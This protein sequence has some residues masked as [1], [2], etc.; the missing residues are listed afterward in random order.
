MTLSITPNKR[1]A[2]NSKLQMTLL[3]M[4]PKKRIRILKTLGR[5]ER[6]QARARIRRQQ[7]VSG[8]PFEP[9]SNGK[10][11]R[12]LKRLG[13]TLEPYVQQ[14]SRLELKH[15]Q[16]LTGRIAALQQ[17]GGTEVMTASKMR[18]IHGQP[19]YDAPASRSQAKAL[20]AEGYKVRKAKGGWRRA[21]LN[22]IQQR[23]SVGQAGVIL[24]AMR[25]SQRKQRWNIPVP[26]REFLGDTTENVQRQLLKII[27]QTG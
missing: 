20:A 21:S 4:P 3:A 19:D 26:A 8:E 12:M 14:A 13:K 2:L 25:D 27:Q 16:T 23:L 1:Q 11:Q 24:R 15:R 17:T 10:K 7:T 6:A 22:E 18:R 9:R 5:Y